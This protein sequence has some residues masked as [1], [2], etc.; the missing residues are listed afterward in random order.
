METELNQAHETKRISQTLSSNLIW[1][2]STSSALAMKKS[3]KKQ[4]SQVQ[5]I[6]RTVT[7]RNVTQDNIKINKFWKGSRWFCPQSLRTFYFLWPESRKWLF[8]KLHLCYLKHRPVPIDQVFCARCMLCLL[9]SWRFQLTALPR[10]TMQRTQ[11]AES[12]ASH[13][14]SF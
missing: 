8:G 2:F 14:Y 1:Q 4:Q 5:M 9:Q 11:N 10:Q 7:S 12:V 3:A 6:Q 13:V